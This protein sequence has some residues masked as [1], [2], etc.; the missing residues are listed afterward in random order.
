MNE[1]RLSVSGQ[2][3]MLNRLKVFSTSLEH[4]IVYK[5]LQTEGPTS[6][7]ELKNIL[8]GTHVEDRTWTP[9]L[10]ENVVRELIRIGTIEEVR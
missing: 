5:V 9:M 4:L 1:L 10:V 3:L 2:R 6:L 7:E 8:V